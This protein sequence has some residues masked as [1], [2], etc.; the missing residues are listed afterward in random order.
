MTYS[1]SLQDY[2]F[3][4]ME[5][6]AAYA[7]QNVFCFAI[8]AKAPQEF[9]ERIHALASCFPNVVIAKNEYRLESSGR[10]L[11]YAYMECFKQLVDHRQRWE[12]VIILQNHDVMIKTTQELVQILKWLNGA[13]DVEIYPVPLDRG[14][15]FNADW[16]FAGL[17]LFKNASRNANHSLT[18]TY[19]LDESAVSR[20]AVEFV[21]NELN[22]TKF[23]Q[24]VNT[25]HGADELVLPTLDSADAL[26]LPGGFTLEC[27]RR[28]IWVPGVTRYTMWMQPAN[29]GNGIMRHNLCVFGTGDLPRLVNLPHLSVNKLM[30]EFD[31]GASVCLHELMFNRT[32]LNRTLSRLNHDLYAKLPQVRYQT[33]RKKPHF[34]LSDFDCDTHESST[35]FH[36]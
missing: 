34:N 2:R 15:D 7:P 32:Y 16:S 20:A 31:F 13:N 19:G 30:P 21:V 17:N 5:F 12:Y 1:G 35:F 25:D 14:V 28:N 9:H 6:A 33:E 29:C 22:V 24:Q 8:D 4:E 23:L 18:L 26:G 10:N 3:L 11:W 27:I 36:G